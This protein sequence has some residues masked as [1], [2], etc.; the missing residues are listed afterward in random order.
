MNNEKG[1][2]KWWQG[3]LI[4]ILS[5]LIAGLFSALLS[6]DFSS[7]E[8]FAPIEKKVDFNV[9]DIYNMIEE[10]RQGRELSE[11]VVVVSVDDLDR[12]QLLT[13]IDTI[14]QY[15]PKA[16]G[17][18]IY[19]SIE[20][21]DNKALI[22]KIQNTPNMVSISRIQKDSDNIH[23]QEENLSF[24]DEK[25]TPPHK[26]YANLDINHSWTVVRTFLPYVRSRS[27][28]IIPSMA[29][30]LVRIAAPERAEEAIR[31]G[32]TEEII[33]FTHQEIEVISAVRLKNPA[34]AQGL[35]GKIVLLGVIEDTKDIYLTPLREPTAG[36]LVH[37][38]A[39]LTILNGQYI[40][41]RATWKNWAIAVCIC[42]ILV[43]LLLYAN[44]NEGLKYGLNLAVRILMFIFMFMLVYIGCAQ[45]ANSHIYADYTPAITMLV[46]G[47]LAFDL[48]YA[49]YGLCRQLKLRRKNK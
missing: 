10:D 13:L 32:N 19:F 43:S 1:E 34:V 49:G 8:I 42:L 33:D 46:F 28:N 14:R 31:R 39:T 7:I 6:S 25:I 48:V 23:Y 11:E 41:T 12:E 2:M 22:N 35:K 16:I 4:V 30:E 36:V 45:F 38:Y 26:G 20:K 21:A 47:T 3:G 17:L 5:V 15:E 18:D 9:S 40:Q 29:L 27:D 24:F 37:A 44:E